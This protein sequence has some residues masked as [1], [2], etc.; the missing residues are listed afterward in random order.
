M[1]Q[2]LQAA[3]NVIKSELF[4]DEANGVKYSGIPAENISALAEALSNVPKRTKLPMTRKQI[5]KNADKDGNLSFFA[6]FELS[7]LMVDVDC[8]NCAVSEWLTGGDDTC[9]EDVAYRMVQVEK[10]G[11]L[12]MEVSGNVSNWLK[13]NS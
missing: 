12:L 13:E 4:V 7:E 11:N 9:L 10:N 3:K 2:V 6:E 1:N 8:L 5:E